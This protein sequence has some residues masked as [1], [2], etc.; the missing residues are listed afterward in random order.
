MKI[1]HLFS[2]SLILEAPDTYSI[3]FCLFVNLLKKLLQ[4]YNFSGRNIT[5]N[6]ALYLRLLQRIT[7]CICQNKFF[8]VNFYKWFSFFNFSV[9]RIPFLVITWTHQAAPANLSSSDASEQ[10]FLSSWTIFFCLSSLLH[11]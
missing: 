10:R 9:G 2:F 1:E 3:I 11:S 8:F 7:K 4:F 6:K 5:R